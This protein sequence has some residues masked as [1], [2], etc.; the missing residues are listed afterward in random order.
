MSGVT[1]YV[2]I[3]LLKLKASNLNAAL[4]YLSYLAAQGR[5]SEELQNLKRILESRLS[6]VASQ[7]HIEIS[8]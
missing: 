6:E 2:E 4:N 1:Y 3:A 8:L 5:M 7:G